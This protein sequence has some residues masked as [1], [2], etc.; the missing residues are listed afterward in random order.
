MEVLLHA[1]M[2]SFDGKG[3]HRVGGEREYVS[4]YI[5]VITKSNKLCDHITAYGF[6]VRLHYSYQG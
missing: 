6:I 1:L 2:A 4:L 5:L 3:H